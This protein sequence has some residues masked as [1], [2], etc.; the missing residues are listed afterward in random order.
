MSV[1]N[2][3][4]VSL[5]VRPFQV[6][7]LCFEVGGILEASPA[8]LGASVEAFDLP[9]LYATMGA[10]PTVSGDLSR[11]LFDPLQIQAAVGPFALASLR[12]EP[13][14]AALKSAINARQN[15]YF[16]KYANAPAIIAQ[17]QQFYGD[18]IGSKSERLATLSFLAQQQFNAL[19]SAYQQDG[20]LGVVK[21]TGSVLNSNTHSQGDTTAPG[22]SSSQTILNTEQSQTIFNT[23]YGYRFPQLE[24]QAQLERAQ[25]SLMDQRFAQFMYVQNLPNLAHVFQNELNSIDS[26]VYRLQIAFLNTI[27]TSPI[28]GTVTGLYKNVGDVVRA[29]EPVARVEDNSTVYLMASVIYRGPVAIGS[30]LT[31]STSP[32]GSEGASAMLTGSVVSARGHRNDDQWDLVVKCNN[33]DSSSKPIF[34]LGY[35]FDYDDT[36]VSIT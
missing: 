19:G 24:N 8:Q 29:G 31:A 1:P 22:S 21:A 9:G 5:S 32:F 6:S 12:A 16:S 13:C 14:K 30:T 3:K 10:A 33:L 28:A 4:P 7:H 35:H 26:N 11:L 25:I 23:D 15:A 18:I 20:R 36:V 27:L 34:P 17:I 2:P